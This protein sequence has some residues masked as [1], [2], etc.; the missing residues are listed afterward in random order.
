[1]TQ[2]ISYMTRVDENT[3]RMALPEGKRK[4]F[5]SYKHA[6]EALLSLCPTLAARILEKF[7]AA[8]WYDHQL[9]AGAAYDSEIRSAI[10]QADAFVLLL[11]PTILASKYVWETEIP[12]AVRH[13]VAVIPVIAGLAEA[14][15]PKVESLIGRVHMPVWFFGQRTDMPAFPKDAFEQFV[16][17][18]KISL[19]SKDL[20]RQ[21]ELF[22]ERGNQH[23]S[24]RYLNP[25]Q[26][27]M[28]AYGELFGL[29]SAADKEV[30]LKLME[31]ILWYS[32]GDEE[33]VSFQRQVALELIKHLYRT[34]Q[35]T[36]FFA[37]LKSALDEKNELVLPLLFD[38]YRN[39][40]HPELL[41]CVP[42]LSMHLLEKLY[43]YCFGEEWDAERMMAGAEKREIKFVPAPA[44]DRPHIGELSFDGH[45]AYFQKAAD[46]TGMV[47]LILDSRCIET[48]ELT[49]SCGDVN[50]LFMAYDE[51]RRALITLCAEFDHYGPETITQGRIYS[52]D[53]EKVLAQAFSSEW[54]R[55][56]RK[57]PYS[58]FTFHIR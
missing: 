58:P 48:Y 6:D 9:T 51:Q 53:G 35:P 36:P 45:T 27:F 18:L 50:F 29:D 4:I 15:V 30:G 46:E 56:M 10:L 31:S 52:I 26:V 16:N 13:Q 7:D 20:L 33:F 19:A 8:V 28:K 24:L 21:A 22:Y 5:I 3:G 41:S 49:A 57:L 32:C 14:D 2:Y 38:L 12:L 23:T 55:G 43:P 40:W 25:E 34:N 47:N 42:A 11:T 17:G 54:V 44:S 37:Y 1:M 39:Q